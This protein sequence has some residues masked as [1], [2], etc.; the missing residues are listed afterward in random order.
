M[1][2]TLPPREEDAVLVCSACGREYG[3]STVPMDTTAL[4]PGLA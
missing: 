2:T 1:S 4:E 3:D